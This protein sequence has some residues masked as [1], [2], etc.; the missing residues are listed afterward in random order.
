MVGNRHVREVLTHT[1]SGFG[2]LDTPRDWTMCLGYWAISPV[3]ERQLCPS[4]ALNAHF[5]EE[6]PCL[7][8]CPSNPSSLA[9][10][11]HGAPDIVD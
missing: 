11:R 4:I 8:I 5:A 2:S 1:G 3:F 7:L 6:A 10:L 9:R